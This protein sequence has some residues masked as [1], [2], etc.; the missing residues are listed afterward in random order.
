M[1]V[2]GAQQ[3]EAVTAVQVWE[4]LDLGL[5]SPQGL[6][7]G[8][9]HGVGSE[10]LPGDY[11]GPYGWACAEAPAG[12]CGS[13]QFTRPGPGTGSL[14]MFVRCS[15]WHKW[16]ICHPRPWVRVC[17]GQC[18]GH[19]RFAVTVLSHQ[20]LSCREVYVVVFTSDPS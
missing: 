13:P 5:R 16:A 4:P 20:R 12:A 3:M 9:V 2:L 11:V 10:G 7:S 19:L 18:H 15:R 6:H 17:H 14:G 1:A 8:G